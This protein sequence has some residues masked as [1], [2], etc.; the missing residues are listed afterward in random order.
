MTAAFNRNLL[1]RVNR[2]LDAD[3]DIDAF[4]HRAIWNA[5]ESRVEMHLVSARSQRIRQSRLSRLDV[6]SKLARRIW[7]ELVQVS[8]RRDRRDARATPA[9]GRSISGSMH[10][11]A[12]R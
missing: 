9:S 11:I 4:E 1:V 10:P 12:S 5:A 2:E 6:D 8:S 3:F 7:T